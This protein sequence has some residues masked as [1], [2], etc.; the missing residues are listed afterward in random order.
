MKP[1]RLNWQFLKNNLGNIEKI[2]ATTGEIKEIAKFLGVWTQTLKKYRKKYNELEQVILNGLSQYKHKPDTT[3]T[4]TTKQLIQVENIMRTGFL[5]DVAKYLNISETTRCKHTVKY[6]ELKTAIEKGIKNQKWPPHVWIHSSLKPDF[7]EYNL[8]QIEKIVERTGLR[9]KVVEFFKI[10]KKT[11]RK[12]ELK[13]PALK[14]A[15]DRGIA[16]YKANKKVDKVASNNST[17]VGVQ[18]NTKSTEL[19]QFKKPKRELVA[20]LSTIED[21]GEENALARYRRM[22]EAEK[23]A[24]LRKQVKSVGEII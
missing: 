5:K 18:N 16:K 17:T 13:Y 21:I 24:A 1:P 2:A 15:I 4:Y 11:L 10:D 22:K 12:T 19:F 7:I 6:P 20:K 9:M 23:E 3:C 8:F 14:I